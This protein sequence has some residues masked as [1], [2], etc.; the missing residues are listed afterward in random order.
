[1]AISAAKHDVLGFV[2]RLDAV[3]T[4]QT[5]NA[6]G[7]SFAL[8]LID[9]VPRRQGCA[10]GHRSLNGNGSR[11]SV[12][13]GCFLLGEH[14]PRDEKKNKKTLNAEHRT[15]NVELISLLF[16]V[17]FLSAVRMLAT[18]ILCD[19]WSATAKGRR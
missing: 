2:H 1:M 9:P 19:S 4:L 5:A 16:H 8:R 6:L 13:G 11:R 12:T 18:K 3:M 10:R 14:R 17:S 15:P 7:V